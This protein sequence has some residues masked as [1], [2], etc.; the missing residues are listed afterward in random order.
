MTISRF[1]H[2]LV[3]YESSRSCYFISNAPVSANHCFRLYVWCSPS[4][5]SAMSIIDEVKFSW[6]I[7]L[8]TLILVLVSIYRQSQSSLI[9]IPFP[10]CWPP[11]CSSCCE[12][13]AWWRRRR[14]G[15]SPPCR[16]WTGSGPPSAQIGCQSV[17]NNSMNKQTNLAITNSLSVPNI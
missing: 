8:L 3:K 17:N 6:T 16:R 12:P 11:W 9:V 7:T 2:L 5:S 1:F 15:A 13:R 10:T 14:R 4:F